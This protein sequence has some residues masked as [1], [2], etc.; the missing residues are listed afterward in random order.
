MLKA[1]FFGYYA[2]Y[3][4]FPTAHLQ[5]ICLLQIDQLFDQLKSSKYLLH[6]HRK[7]VWHLQ[8]AYSETFRRFIWLLRKAQF[9]FLLC[10]TQIFSYCASPNHSSTANRPI[11]SPL[12]IVQIINY[13]AQTY[14][15]TTSNCLFGNISTIYTATA[16]SQIFRLLRIYHCASAHLQII[17]VQQID[18]LFQG[19]KSST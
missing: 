17:Y 4:Y 12:E 3:N 15:M 14:C 9:L 7:I 13:S 6:V 2:S 11:I 8:I 18:K 19:W 1:Q 5:I 16:K 10:I